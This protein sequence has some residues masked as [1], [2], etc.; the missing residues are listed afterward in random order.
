ME[1]L[2][3]TQEAIGITRFLTQDPQHFVPT[4]NGR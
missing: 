4:T 2:S 1:S 3:P